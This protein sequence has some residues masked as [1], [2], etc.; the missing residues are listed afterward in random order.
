[1]KI[2]IV[3][4]YHYLRG[5]DCR[6]ALGLA[7]LLE[8]EGHEVFH[9]AMNS[10]E[11]LPCSEVDYFVSEIDFR[12]AMEEGG[13]V[14]AL[15]VLTRTLYSRE[16]QQNLEKLLE[17]V[18]PDIAHL[19]SIRHHL[20]K[21]ILPV[22][23]RR[24]VPVLWTLHDF[25]ELCP[26]TSFF[27]GEKI[28]EKCLKGGVSQVFWNRCKKGSFGASLI[29]WAE[30][31]FNNRNR[32]EKY[33]NTYISPSRFL[34]EKFLSCGYHPDKMVHIPNFMELEA[35]HPCESFENYLLFIG[36]LEPGKGIETLI[37]GFGEAG[38][39]DPSLRLKIAGSGT[40]REK[41]ER[42]IDQKGIKGV[43]FTG[44][45][46]GADLEAVIQH[47]K[48]VVIPS[49]L[50]ENYPFSGLEAMAYGKPVIG[51]RIGGIP[52]QVTDG[53]TGF[54]FTPFD[55]RDLC[56]KIHQ[57]NRLTPEEI[58]EMGRKAR[59]KVEAINTPERYMSMLLPIY[60][61]HARLQ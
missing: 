11:N 49:E 42:L 30:V 39:L 36:R 52:E 56:E 7:R 14:N 16:A 57:L 58:H 3:N 44:F 17:A 48:A 22:C 51:S 1:M 13:V 23:S 54:L 32:F 18:Q 55:H 38:K 24:G 60:E 40:L 6:H 47:A 5:G 45:L 53:V 43:E 20:T 15:K 28:C 27:D 8:K 37:Q 25:K 33:V 46:G 26:N 61:K 29:A 59:E 9:F 50:Y 21:S 2:L 12:K 35:F 10:R 4:T 34:M 31:V 19:H 41:I